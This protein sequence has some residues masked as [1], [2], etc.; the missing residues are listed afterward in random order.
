MFKKIFNLIKKLV[1]ENKIAETEE[2]FWKGYFGES[3]EE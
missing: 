1:L 3:N 2:R